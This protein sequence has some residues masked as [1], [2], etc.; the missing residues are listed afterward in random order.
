MTWEAWATVASLRSA[1]GLTDTGAIHLSTDRVL[2]R[3]P[4]TEL[5]NP[6]G[7]RRPGGSDRAWP[8]PWP[9]GYTFCLSA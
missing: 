6:R 1:A 3:P 4:S 2:G 9:P 8:G 5:I 7:R